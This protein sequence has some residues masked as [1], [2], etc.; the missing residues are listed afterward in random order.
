MATSIVVTGG[1]SGHRKPNKGTLHLS[2]GL[3]G[4]ADWLQVHK[5]ALKAEGLVKGVAADFLEAH[6]GAFKLEVTGVRSRSYKDWRS[7]ENAE[8]VHDEVT[9]FA[10][11]FRDF[12]H[13]SAMA[14]RVREIEDVGVSVS[15][16]LG[17][18]KALRLRAKLW[19][20]AV[21]DAQKKAAA[22][23]AAA[24]L[25]L[26]GVKAIADPGMLPGSRSQAEGG[27]VDYGLGLPASVSGEAGD[28][29]IDLVPAPIE[30]EVSVEAHFTAERQR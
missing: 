6:P 2:A 1:A 26:T 30:F 24:G 23:A 12:D 13:L 29:G 25:E 7:D 10:L 20:E 3:T 22:Y 9:Y 16:E 5:R 11:E 4:G 17:R 15:W 8:I 21:A 19:G 28:G 14:N 27:H 18:A